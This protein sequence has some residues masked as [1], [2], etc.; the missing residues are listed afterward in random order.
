MVVAGSVA[1]LMKKKRRL[2]GKI[3][4][5][6]VGGEGHVSGPSFLQPHWFRS[7]LASFFL[8]SPSIRCEEVVIMFVKCIQ[9]YKRCDK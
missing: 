9:R 6:F 8:P 4:S 2:A 7:L 3:L 1:F 5:P